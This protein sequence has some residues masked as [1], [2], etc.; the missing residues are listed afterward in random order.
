MTTDKRQHAARRAALAFGLCAVLACGALTAAAQGNQDGPESP[1]RLSLPGRD[2]A[3]DLSLPGFYR[4]VD[5]FSAESGERMLMAAPTGGKKFQPL[6]VRMMPAKRE[7]GA[8]E[9]R[10][11]VLAS[12]KKAHG[13]GNQNWKAYEY[14]EIPLLKHKFDLSLLFAAPRPY[15]SNAGFP[16]AIHHL[17]AFFA[18][19]GVWVEIT[20][21]AGTAGEK[22]EKAL[23]AVL[24][25]VKLVDTSAPATSLDFY[26]KGRP[27]YMAADYK[28]AAEFYGRAVELE[29]RERRLGERMWRELV[30]DTARAYGAS[31]DLGASQATIEYGLSREPNNPRFH[32]V[33]AVIHAT[34]DDLDQTIAALEKAFQHK[35]ALGD[36]QRLPDP[37]KHPPFQRFAKNEKF[38][39]ATKNM[40]P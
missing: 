5:T 36:D 33:M 20:L 31:D 23:Q 34:R 15:T 1:Q 32:F 35:S 11:F 40:K 8:K 22:E 27:Y 13:S 12:A 18:R 24:D 14:G 2:W 19:D 9:F 21:M 7:G 16:Q 39:Q 10:D 28:K 30:E 3:L 37:R 29:R 17:T 26:H 4:I 6:L 38:R 25:T